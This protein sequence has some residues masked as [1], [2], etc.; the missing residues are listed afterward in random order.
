MTMNLEQTPLLTDLYELTMLQAYY[1]HDM[2]E[3]AVFELF[4]RRSPQRGFFVAAGLEQGLEWLSQLEFGPS[5]LEWMQQ[6][7]LF[8]SAFIE[9]MQRFR[10]TGEVRALPEGSVFFAEEPLVQIVAPLPEAQFIESRLM[11]ILHYQ[12]LIASKAARCMLAAN[13]TPV[14][15]F[16]MRRA[17]G[18]EAGLWAA[19][20]CYMAGFS[21]TATCLSSARYNIPASGTMAHAFILAHD[22]EAQAFERFARSHPDNVVLLI[23]TYDVKRGAQ[24]VVEVA[25]SLAAE[26]LQVHGVRIDSGDLAANAKIAR[27]ILDRGGLTKTRIIVSGGLD[28]YRLETLMAE[29]APID[30]VGVGSNVDTSADSPFLDSAYKLHYFRDRPRGKHAEGKTDLPGRKQVFRHYDADGLLSEDTLGLLDENLEGDALL[31]P[32]MRDGK[33]LK[34]PASGDLDCARAR[35]EKALATLPAPLKQ[36]RTP[37]QHRVS[38][39]PQLKALREELAQS[40]R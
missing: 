7:G 4:M 35:C 1:E 37:G 19:R 33:R 5:E 8:S 20:A 13:G 3:E 34:M 21:A 27:D 28:E 32:V 24:R 17:H 9:R 15:D 23:D 2:T 10:F 22:S 16:G 29:G 31:E 6:T 26:G 18:G 40:Y 38:L 30:G 14:I 39:S 11:N 25:Q 36:L 12:T